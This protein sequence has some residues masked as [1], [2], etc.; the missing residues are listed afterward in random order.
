MSHYNRINNIVGW[1]VFLIAAIVYGITIEPTASFWDAGEFIACSYK[2][3]V[4]HPPGAPF[5]LLVGRIFS[6]FA[7]DDVLLV[8]PL[9]NMLS[10]LVSAGTVLFLFWTITI[11]ARKMLLQSAAPQSSGQLLLIIGSG[12]VGALAFTFSDS[13]WFSAVEAEV[14]G[15]SSFFTAFVFW[16][17]LKWEAKAQEGAADK[18]LILIAYMVGLSIGVHLLNLLAIPALAFIFYYRKQGKISRKGA[19]ITFL[20]SAVI[21][22]LI[23]W[24]I[25]PGLPSV[26]GS[27]EVFFINS[28]GL[29]FGTGIIIFLVLFFAA[30]YFGFRYSLRNRKRYLN[31]ALL[32]FVYIL[33]GYSSYLIIPIRS[34]YD[35]TIDENDPENIV[36][37][38]SYLKREQYGDR[39]LLFGPQFTAEVIDQEQGEPRYVKGENKYEVVD[40]KIE[41]VYDPKSM[42]LLP[43][44]YSNQPQHIQEYKKWVDIQEGVKPTMGQN[45]SFLFKY[46]FGHMYWR[47]SGGILWAGRVTCRMRPCFGRWKTTRAYLTG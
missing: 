29:P 41:P 32:C 6:M 43:R 30:I 46:Q 12:V 37:F 33:I 36:S 19:I 13:F 45:L 26:A 35:P 8:A 31:T 2:L 20:I 9:V 40:H 16:A 15:M 14:Y 28:L 4:P 23:L 7:G 18:W 10:A 38:V 5:Y 24:G 11:L 17:M 1:A 44:I 22:V 27:F 42:S 25:I 34:T 3:L 47:Y 39:P 21:I